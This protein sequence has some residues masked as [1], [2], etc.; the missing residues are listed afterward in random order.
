MPRKKAE[1][2]DNRRTKQEHNPSSLGLCLAR[3]R[4]AK[5]TD[6]GASG[7]PSLVELSRA[8][9]RKAKPMT[10]IS[11]ISFISVLI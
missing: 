2:N 7:E 11:N 4:K 1:D 10:T 3:R 5:P 9:R 8:R 6:E